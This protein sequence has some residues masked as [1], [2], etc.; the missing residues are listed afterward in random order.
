MNM[1]KRVLL[2]CLLILFCVSYGA[3]QQAGSTKVEDNFYYKARLASLEK[4]S[5][6]YGGF[7]DYRN[8]I[9]EKD[10]DITEGL[11]TQIGKSHVEYLGSQ[12]LI[13]RYQ[14]LKKKFPIFAQL[15]QFSDPSN[16]SV[17]SNA[18][19][20]QIAATTSV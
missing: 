11:P 18:S 12:E 9:V 6:A 14:K 2:S 10:H 3:S 15:R 19:S 1:M 5:K 7:S 13:D 16:R 4:M 20:H 17:I 8:I